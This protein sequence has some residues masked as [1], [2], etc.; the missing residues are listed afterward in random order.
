MFVHG[1]DVLEKRIDRQKY[2]QAI[3]R[4]WPI[5]EKA[6]GKFAMYLLPGK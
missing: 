4:R 6:L 2:R 1:R 3:Q 5:A